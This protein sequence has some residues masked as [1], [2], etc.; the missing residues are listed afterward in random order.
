MRV[1]G[2]ILSLCVTASN[3]SDSKGGKRSV[4][5]SMYNSV[6]GKKEIAEVST[7]STGTAV[8][9]HGVKKSWYDSSLSVK[10]LKADDHNILTS[11]VGR[12]KS[13][14]FPHESMGR[15][16]SYW[17]H[18]L[19]VYRDACLLSNK[20]FEC[21]TG[22]KDA[23]KAVNVYTVRLEKDFRASEVFLLGLKMIR[24][25][26]DELILPG[27]SGESTS[28]SVIRA[29]FAIVPK[30]AEQG[31]NE[32]E[33]TKAYH[34]THFVGL[35]NSK[36]PKKHNVKGRVVVGFAEAV[37]MLTVISDLRNLEDPKPAEVWEAVKK[38]SLTED[39]KLVSGNPSGAITLEE[40]MKFSRDFKRTS[41]A[42]ITENYKS[43]MDWLKGGAEGD[44]PLVGK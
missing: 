31:Y 42:K 44:W 12:H 11:R 35:N 27:G 8:D 30:A 10:S 1:G 4:F 7:E 34:M 29:V 16:G 25:W 41:I 15:V 3:G 18:E 28:L 33:W 19:D 17:V 37:L 24:D 26:E 14:F 40:A 2:F 43:I 13:V 23:Q 20:Y 38:A 39:G 32:L 21:K 9:S 22:L 6:F 36:E 5:G